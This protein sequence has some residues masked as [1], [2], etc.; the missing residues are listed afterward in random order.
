MGLAVGAG[1]VLGFLYS[2]LK[3]QET[4]YTAGATIL[5]QDPAAATQGASPPD[6]FVTS[7]VQ[8]MQS[9]LVM[10]EAQK[11]LAAGS[12]P[13]TVSVTELQDELVVLSGQG[14]PL[15]TFTITDSKAE[16]AVAMANGLA[17]AYQTVSRSQA[18]RASDDALQRIDAE[19]QALDQRSTALEQ[20]IADARASDT[21]LSTLAT[22]ARDAITRIADLQSKLDSASPTAAAAIQN[23]ITGLRTRID[24]YRQVTA[25]IPTP[26]ALQALQTEQGQ[27]ATRRADLLQ[28]RDQISIDADLAPDAVASLIQAVGASRVPPPGP[29]RAVA[30]GLILGALAGV[31]IAYLQTMRRRLFTDRMEPASVLDAPLLAEVP[32]FEAEGLDSALPVRDQPRSAAAEAFRFAAA[33]L[34]FAMRSRGAKTVMIVSATIGQGKTTSVVNTAFASA[35]EGRSVLVVDCDFGN[36]DTTMLITGDSQPLDLGLTDFVEAGA[37]PDDTIQTIE[38]GNEI[39]IGLLSRGRRATVAANVIRHPAA[40]Q[41]FQDM[42]A[43]YD[44]VFVDGPPVLQ[45]AYASTL[46]GYVDAVVVVVSHMTPWAHL[47]DLVSRL[48]LIGTPIVG[49][50]YNKTPLRRE[51]VTS[52]G[53]MMDILGEFG[54][55]AGSTAGEGGRPK[56][57]RRP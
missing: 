51:M 10:S 45:V 25:V 36:Q 6:R 5:L 18:T 21:A 1:I 56:R 9:P 27:N 53:S 28:R 40:Q 50:L 37:A 38:L 52:E 44:L 19:I 41:L 12:P 43:W 14:S 39:S 48:K 31:G 15:V 24:V 26:T 8:I 23:E 32:D 54:R 35:R 30:V 11:L 13:V 57:D 4:L 49:Y 20:Q 7:Q 34:E 29:A 33:A 17:Q 3:P 46:V 2:Q 42:H 16:R 55:S 22:Q 47:E